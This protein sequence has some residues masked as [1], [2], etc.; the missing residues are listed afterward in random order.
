MG[1]LAQTLLPLT[2][3][4]SEE[5]AEYCYGEYGSGSGFDVCMRE[6]APGFAPVLWMLVIIIGAV[7]AHKWDTRDRADKSA[8]SKV[9]TPYADEWFRIVA[10]IPPE[11]WHLYPPIG[12]RADIQPFRAGA[13]PGWYVWYEEHPEWIAYWDGTKFMEESYH[14]NPLEAP[15]E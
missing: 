12:V 10:D 1:T 7:V 4:A 8:P 9:V 3:T 13:A 6:N 11:E 15:T 14:E 2:V 5:L